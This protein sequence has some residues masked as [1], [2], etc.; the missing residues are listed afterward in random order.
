[1]VEE[2]DRIKEVKAQAQHPGL[3]NKINQ[4]DLS[5]EGAGVKS[6]FYFKIYFTNYKQCN[7]ISILCYV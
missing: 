3:I 7:F 4:E 2:G 1:V 5:L 6:Y